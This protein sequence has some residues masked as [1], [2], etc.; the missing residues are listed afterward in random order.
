VA[1]SGAGLGITN[2]D[3]VAGDPT[4]A[5]TG[6][7]AA[8]A[9]VYGNGLVTVKTDGTVSST[10]INGTTSQVSVTNGNAVSGAPTIG[11]ADDP[12]LPGTGGVVIPTGTTAQQPSG[13]PGLFRFNS[14][15]QTFDGYA[16][17]SWRQ[18]SLT[19]GVISFSG[20]AT[21]LLP[22]TPT[23]G[24]VT[25]DGVLNPANGGTG[26][27]TLSGYVYGNGTS[28]M[29]ASTTIP[30]TNLSGTVSN[31]QLANSSVTINGS[32]VSLGGSTTVTAIA[33]NALTI[34]TGSERNKLQRI[35]ASDSGD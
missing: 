3:G 22:N 16:S 34:G 27:A 11:L 5:L 24:A 6:Q 18:F 20:G 15:T 8:F 35:S 12:I 4:L 9:S 28:A 25:L 23:S 1:V 32:T 31:S 33:S 10:T 26:A 17:G 19:G 7:A 13:T 14:T 21:G 2:G 29:T 30:T